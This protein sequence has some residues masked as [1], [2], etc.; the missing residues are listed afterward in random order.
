MARHQ[1]RRTTTL[2][3][4]IKIIEKVRKL[5]NS[6]LIIMDNSRSNGIVI[7]DSIP[8]GELNTA[9]R[10]K[11]ELNDIACYVADGLNVHYIRVDTISSLEEGISY[12]LNEIRCKGLQPWIHLE[13]HGLSDESGFQL[14]GSEQ[15]SW[16][17]L[18]ELVTPINISMGLNLVLVLALCFGGSFASVIRTIDCAPVLGLIGPKREVTIG[19]IEK[20]FPSF[21][22]T[23]FEQLSLKKAIETLNLSAPNLYYKTSAERFFYDV[24]AKYKK[25]ACSKEEIDKRVRKMYRIAKSKDLQRTPSIGQ[26]KRLLRSKESTLFEKY[27]DTYFMYDIYDSNRTRFPV[28]Y[29]KAEIYASRQF[30]VIQIYLIQCKKLDCRVKPGNDRFSF[31]IFY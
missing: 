13:A 27:R 9:R 10:L 17:Q 29:K 12:V 14:A 16:N 25:E 24:W 19:E 5:T 3:G 6:A 31:W 4:D 11:E 30:N 1:G 15:Y 18:K 21:Y 28:T 8:Q 2:T 23:L 7:L 26:L 20:G 22:R